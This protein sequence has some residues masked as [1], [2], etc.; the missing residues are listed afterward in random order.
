L[1]NQVLVIGP[2]EYSLSNLN[3]NLDTLG[4][5]LV[6]S[7]QPLVSQLGTIVTSIASG[8]ASVIGSLVLVIMVTYFILSENKGRPYRVVELNI[9]GYEDDIEHMGLELQRIWNGF[10]RGQLTM[11]GITFLIYSILLTSLG[12]RFALGLAIMAG[13]A[14]FI[15]WLGTAVTWVV[16]FLVA[17]LQGSTIFGLQPF[18]YALLVIGVS[19]LMDPVIDSMITP[20]IMGNALRVHP[21]FLLVGVFVGTAWLGFIG[22]LLAGPVLATIKLL[23]T[24]AFRKS[25]DRDPW[26]GLDDSRIVNQPSGLSFINPVWQKIK[27]WFEKIWQKFR[28]GNQPG[29]DN[30]EK[31]G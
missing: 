28:G 31:D 25:F 1:N 11:V 18:G 22:L 15:P 12:M 24:Y 14:R 27:N 17:L 4:Q 29:P 19:M 20:R 13:F 7:I 26:E 3:L 23:V 30:S 9:P 2:F 5:Q 21:A 16:Y 10:L 6:A 8:A